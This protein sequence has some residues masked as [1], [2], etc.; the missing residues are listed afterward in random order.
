MGVALPTDTEFSIGFDPERHGFSF[1]NWSGVTADDQV[2]FQAVARLL[3]RYGSCTITE[4]LPECTLR[5]G[6][7]INRERLNEALAGGRCEGMVVL[8]AQLF[9]DPQRIQK[10]SRTATSAI[11]LNREQANLEIN[12]WWVSQITP[13]I[14]QFSERSRKWP[15]TRFTREVMLNM[16]LG[17]LVSLGLVTDDLAHSVLPIGGRYEATETVLT[18]FD[19]NFP[20]ETKELHINNDTGDWRYPFARLADGSIGT[21]SGTRAGLD[22]V[23]IALRQKKINWE[24]PGWGDF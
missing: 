17:T 7:L 11:D 1:A 20:Q 21:L 2:T 23:P 15:V 5:S 13:E 3:G 22:Y 24:I 14:R 9:M 16:R 18:I 10:I 8:A 19:P 4:W 12:Y 6:S